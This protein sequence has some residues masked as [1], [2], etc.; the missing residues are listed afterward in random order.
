MAHR[1]SPATADL[2]RRQALGLMAAMGCAVVAPA[3]AEEA[4]PARPIKLVV[5]WPAG[6][7]TDIFGRVVARELAARLGTPVVVDNRAGATGTIGV[8]HVARSAADGTTLLFA[9]T[10]AV[11]GSI[12]ALGDAP[13]PF[14]PV[15]DFAPLGLLVETAVVLW[16]H[17]S[18]GLASFEQF[19]ARARDR[20]QPPVP[21]GTTGTGAVSELAVEQL[22]RHFG[23]NL[24][25]VPYRGTAPQ[26]ADLAAG[27]VQ[28]G[29]A[30]Y[31]VAEGH[32]QSGRLRPLLVIGKER[33]PELPDTPTSAE[34]GITEPDF[35]IWN[36]AFAPAATPA[37]ILVRLRQ[38]LQQIGSGDAFRAV[39]E[40]KGNR[41][42]FQTGAE[43]TARLQ[44]EL[45]GRRAFDRE[46]SAHQG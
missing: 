15:A 5:P 13:K 4:W 39:A 16:A 19:L 42:I 40:G 32:V 28:V 37:P 24:L 46:A 45:A 44:A 12:A 22:G 18:T 10:T 36:G 41:L 33:L 6:G 3:Q 26:V 31:P 29:A 25:K 21:F 27:H 8:Q 2:R 43:A 35:T 7:P 11:V 1:A 38:E 23:L 9:N 17:Q 30:D 14:D 20:A 34:Y